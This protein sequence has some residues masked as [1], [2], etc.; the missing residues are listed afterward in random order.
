MRRGPLARASLSLM[1]LNGGL[2][3]MWSRPWRL[4]S[5]IAAQAVVFQVDAANQRAD[6]EARRRLECVVVRPRWLASVC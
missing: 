1:W 5:W 6:P 3:E 2:C 4:P